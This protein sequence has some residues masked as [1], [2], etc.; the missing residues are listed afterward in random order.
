[1]LICGE[2]RM[3]RS[4]LKQKGS[5]DAS[6]CQLS[7]VGVNMI[8]GPPTKSVAFKFQIESGKLSFAGCEMVVVVDTGQSFPGSSRLD[9]T[10]CGT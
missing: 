10:D 8:G 7:D 6:K 3:L 1:M 2:D 9:G 5:G 4:D